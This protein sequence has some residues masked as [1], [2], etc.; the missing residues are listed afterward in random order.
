MLVTL[1]ETQFVFCKKGNDSELMLEQMA[2]AEN[3]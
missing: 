1:T 2:T 3:N